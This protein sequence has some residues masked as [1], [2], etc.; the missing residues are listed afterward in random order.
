M[1]LSISRRTDIP[2]LYGEWLTNRFKKGYVYVRNPVYRNKVSKIVLDKNG[3]DGIVFWTKNAI[4]FMQYVKKFEEYPFYFQYTIT[5]YDKT[6]EK[7]LPDKEVIISNFIEL[8]NRIGKNRV[9]W[10]Y[11][12]ILFTDTISYEYHKDHFEYLCQKLSPYTRKCIISFMDF[13]RKGEKVYK[14]YGLK[15][16]SEDSVRKVTESIFSIGNEYNLNI[17]TCC[18]AIDLEGYGIRH[19]K[20]I[21]SEI[22][23]SLTDKKYEVKKDKGQRRECRCDESIDLGEYDS[24]TNGCIYCYASCNLEKACKNMEQH[25]PGSD[26]LIGELGAEDIVIERKV[27]SRK[28]NQ[29]LF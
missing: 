1:F 22:F 12:P 19:G 2:C 3:I 29:E 9:I 24:C 7:G 26:L 8:S 25:N 16:L 23:T 5:P 18:E 6:I 11:D 10:R 27:N 4:N 21:D 13:Y 15:D 17:E 20:C 28:S 14:T